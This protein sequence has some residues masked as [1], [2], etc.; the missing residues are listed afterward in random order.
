MPESGAS[1]LPGQATQTELPDSSKPA[2]QPEPGK[3]TASSKPPG[4]FFG[5]R[6]Q[7]D[8]DEAAA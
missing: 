7:L 1:S 4:F 5:R 3:T 8:R 6:I 2:S